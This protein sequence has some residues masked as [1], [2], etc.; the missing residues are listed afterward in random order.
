MKITVS[1]VI[2][3]QIYKKDSQELFNKSYV[4]GYFLIF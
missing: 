1:N 2:S 3:M 4:I